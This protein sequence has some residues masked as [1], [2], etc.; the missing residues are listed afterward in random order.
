MNRDYQ[1]SWIL[2]G[3][4]V[5]FA[6][7]AV[8]FTLTFFAEAKERYQ[9]ILAIV[10]LIVFLS[11]P[12]LKY[13]WFTG[14]FI[15]QSMQYTLANHIITTGSIASFSSTNTFSYYTASPFIHIL[16][17]SFSL[18]TNVS[19][20]STMKFVP[21]LFAPLFPL[22]TY[23]ILKK[24]DFTQNS[25]IVKFGLFVA[26]IP[27]A[28]SEFIVTGTTFG[29]LTSFIVIYLL[30]SL[31]QKSDR[32]YWVLCIVFDIVLAATHPV[33]SM[34]L[35]VFILL[36][37]L[38]QGFRKYKP[39]FN[40][41][42]TIALSLASVC[43]GWLLFY[44]Y[45]P[46]DEIFKSF[47]VLVPSGSTFSNEYI[48]PTFFSLINANLFQGITT[49]LVYYG[50]DLICLALMAVSILVLIRIRK[51]LKPAGLFVFLFSV[52]AFLLM[53]LGLVIKL[54]TT[55]T[56]PFAEILYP[57]FAAVAIYYITKSR[58]WL[59]P[60]IFG[61]ILVLM[62]FQFY[63]A[64]PLIPS[65]NILY[66]DAPASEPLGY[67]NEVNTAYQRA[68]ISF[69]LSHAGSATIA[70]DLD[71]HSQLVTQVGY[72]FLDSNVVWWDPLNPHY[73]HLEYYLLITHL[74]GKAGPLQE[75]ANLR[76]PE[77]INQ[78]I[79]NSSLVYSNG[80]TYVFAH[81]YHP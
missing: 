79:L 65:A 1:D 64:Q 69:A 21:L 5:P 16:F 11:I 59:R 75:T 49:F 52:M 25:T 45:S 7:F 73:A 4:E 50:L 23:G 42:P 72:S 44:G 35:T 60:L 15:D 32:R 19:L 74:A 36:I 18:A 14:V 6:F 46:L 53:V 13:T 37:A 24:L 31:F 40:L 51:T 12:S 28:R 77:A 54:G 20:N 2:E 71:T 34:I 68:V 48:P 38:Y 78:G 58:K 43:L 33:S 39:D 80:E 27:H 67:V 26:A 81:N 70:A 61:L 9:L 55:R 29:I 66:K 30:V 57:I 17:S 62:V 63:G 47:L 3:L 76:E 56:L 41:R 8:I 22:L 10:G